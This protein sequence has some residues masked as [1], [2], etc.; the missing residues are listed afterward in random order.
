MESGTAGARLIL[1]LGPVA[2]AAVGAFTG[3]VLGYGFAFAWV[4]H[5]ALMAWIAAWMRRAQPRLSGRYWR[6][7]PWESTLYRLLGVRVYA[8]ALRRVGWDRGLPVASRA[9]AG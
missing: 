1:L 7:R 9:R 6:P 5:F 2:V 4:V 3:E 8:Q